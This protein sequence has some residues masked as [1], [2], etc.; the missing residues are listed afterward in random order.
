VVAPGDVHVWWGALDGAPWWEPLAVLL[1]DEER[2]R[3][4]RLR[5]PADRLRTLAAWSL[6]RALLAGCGA[7][8][9]RALA[10]ARGAQGKPRLAAGPPGLEFNLAHSGEAVLVAVAS[11]RAVGV[12]VEQERPGI[13]AEAA[14]IC[15]PAEATALAALA[16]ARRSAGFFACWTRKEAY[17]KARGDGLAVE[18]GSFD[19]AV[20][21]DAPPRL[22]ATRHDPAD[23]GRWALAALPAIPGH[24]ASV[25]A[26]GGGWRPHCWRIQEPA[27]SEAWLAALA[28]FE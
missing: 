6:A 25:A 8:R 15:S 13:A 10:F 21:P 19:V 26:L 20:D 27:A 11:A 4:A 14:G 5:L 2:E 17:L 23:A 1:G 9:A 16:P 3:A 22:L 28:A 18:P 12:D 24:A 7:G